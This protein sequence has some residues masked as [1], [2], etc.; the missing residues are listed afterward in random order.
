MKPMKVLYL[1]SN[2]ERLSGSNRS[3]LELL[4]KLPKHIAP[5]VVTMGGGSLV[6]VCRKRAIETR[7]VKPPLRLGATLSQ[8]G[9][10]NLAFA[11]ASYGP[12]A[13]RLWKTLRAVRADIVHANDHKAALFVGPPAKLLRTPLVTHARGNSPFRKIADRGVRRLLSHC[14]DR[15]SDRVIAVSES[16]ARSLENILPKAKVRVVP[17]GISSGAHVSPEISTWITGMKNEGTIVIST[18]AS[19]VPTKGIH[20]LL[21]SIAELAQRGLQNKF[22]VLVV[23]DFVH[24]YEQYEQ[25][26]ISRM[27]ELGLK[28]VTFAGWQADPTAFYCLTD[29]VVL[30][31]VNEQKLLIN[32]RVLSVIGTEGFPRTV[33]EAMT[34]SLPVVAT[35]VAGVREQVVDS[36]TGFIVRDQQPKELADKMEVLINNQS[37]RRT[38]G[39][40]GKARAE[41]MFSAERYSKGVVNVYDELFGRKALHG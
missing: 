41:T 8:I 3:L 12:Y 11:A 34:Y 1:V 5:V 9:W 33:L 27:H 19:I 24:G 20:W 26:L 23:G 21:E 22:I 15:F 14:Y 38:F 16:T 37:L 29:I 28:N 18:F 35:D 39:A 40:A 2:P 25:L 30:S 32:D 4:G 17:N 31:S 36:K 6:E 7:L 13:I 10:I